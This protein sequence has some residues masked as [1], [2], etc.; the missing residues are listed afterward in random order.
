MDGREITIARPEG[1]ARSIERHAAGT[2]GS[3]LSRQALERRQPLVKPR[4]V[5][6]SPR[7]SRSQP[8]PA[9]VGTSS[10]RVDR[11]ARES[12]WARNLQSTRP[13][14]STRERATHTARSSPRSA[15]A[16]TG[17]KF[18]AIRQGADA[19]QISP[20]RTNELGSVGARDSRT[21]P[22]A[23]QRSVP[24]PQSRQRTKPAPRTTA[25]QHPRVQTRRPSGESQPPQIQRQAAESRRP[26]ERS[27]PPRASRSR[28]ESSEKDIGRTARRRRR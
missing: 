18:S 13:S 12:S 27:Q 3:A 1:V 6:T 11:S 20:R 23:S 17:S 2:V 25:S 15:R 16:P 22:S 9:A 14:Q 8:A 21:A 4:A 26:P 7:N 24:S 10:P 5:D 28:D 19:R